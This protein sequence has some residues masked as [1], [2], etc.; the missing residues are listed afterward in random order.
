[1]YRREARD[2]RTIAT[3]AAAVLDDRQAAVFADLKPE[4]VRQQR[5]V[6]Q[7]SALELLCQ[8]LRTADLAAVEVLVP[9]GEILDGR[10][11]AA[12]PDDVVVTAIDPPPAA[13]SAVR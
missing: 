3:R 1:M 11:Q 12:L 5:I 6:V 13:R 8:E 9:L 2:V 4:G 10:H 7:L